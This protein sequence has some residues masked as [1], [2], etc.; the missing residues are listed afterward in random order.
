MFD[1][2]AFLA[3]ERVVCPWK[4]L[5]NLVCIFR[6]FMPVSVHGIARHMPQWRKLSSSDSS[7]RVLTSGSYV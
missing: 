4:D 2:R 6:V 7:F 1:L 3:A 5:S